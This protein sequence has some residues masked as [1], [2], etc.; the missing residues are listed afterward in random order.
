LVESR[1]RVVAI[2]VGIAGVGKSTVIS[3]AAELL[4]QKNTKATI[5]VFG[6]LMF[7]ESKKMGLKNRDEMRKL[8]IEDQ[9][10]LQD[11]AAKKIAQMNEEILIIDT[12]MFI[13][14]TEGYYPGI[15]SRLLE[16]LKPSYLIMI[17]AD[18]AE[19]VRRRTTD[20]TRDRDIISLENIRNEL[21]ISKAMVATSSVLT[22]SPFIL[23]A[24]DN[25]MIDNAA[26]TIVN[27]LA[28][29]S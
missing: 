12:H 21:E 13:N 15:P 27:V 10:L 18:P 28:K 16:I 1:K 14:T 5:I 11:I 8:S 22:G 23:I 4:S 2:V 26:S 17:A 19:I 9:H 25:G 3:R 20:N 29:G 24:N 7:E 6:T